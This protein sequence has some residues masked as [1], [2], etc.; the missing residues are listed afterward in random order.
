M[1][2][3]KYTEGKIFSLDDQYEPVD[4]KKNNINCTD[5]QINYYNPTCPKSI[6]HNDSYNFLNRKNYYLNIGNEEELNYEEETIIDEDL[7]IYLVKKAQSNNKRIE[8]NESKE[9]KNI[10]SIPN[11]PTSPTSILF[12]PQSNS[13]FFFG[14]PDPFSEIEYENFPIHQQC[15]NPIKTN[16]LNNKRIESNELKGNHIINK[17]VKITPLNNI[18][19]EKIPLP[20]IIPNDKTTINTFTLTQIE[21]TAATSTTKFKRSKTFEETL[22]KKEKK[23]AIYN[24]QNMGRKKKEEKEV[25]ENKTVNDKYRPDNIRLRY[26]RGFLSCLIDFSNFL[27]G[28]SPKLKNKGKIK[29]LDNNIVL[30]TKKEHILAMLNTP[31]KIYLSKNINK[32]SKKLSKDHNEQLIKYIYEVNE[33]KVTKVLDKNMGELMNIFCKNIIIYDNYNYFTLQYY[34]DNVLKKK[35]NENELY[36]SKFIY[37]ALNYEEIYKKLDGRSEGK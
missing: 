26:K 30:N 19:K 22:G 8:S 18:Q 24:K 32:K 23:R 37:Q 36:I 17:K 25:G 5:L 9:D 3:Y 34:I 14:G 16:Q 2:Y 13:S 31:A 27:I 12:N 7:S 28:L 29:K 15:I 11:D 21:K 35:M 33:I 4:S 20:N 6:P 10:N 1:Y